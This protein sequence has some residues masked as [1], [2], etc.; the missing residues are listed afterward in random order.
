M[1]SLLDVEPVHVVVAVAA[2]LCAGA[3][4][5]AFE[6]LQLHIISIIS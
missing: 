4:A 2:E 6:D 5:S 1:P 3:A